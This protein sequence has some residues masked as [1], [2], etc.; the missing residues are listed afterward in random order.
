LNIL[1]PN[2][3]DLMQGGIK[4]YLAAKLENSEAKKVKAPRFLPEQSLLLA[5]WSA[6]Q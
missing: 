1:E 2:E 5:K 4:G 3:Y 6:D